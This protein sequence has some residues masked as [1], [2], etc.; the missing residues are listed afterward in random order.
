MPENLSPSPVVNTEAIFWTSSW[1]FHR[2]QNIIPLLQA[3]AKGG[4]H[5][6]RRPESQRWYLKARWQLFLLSEHT[7]GWAALPRQQYPCKPKHAG[8]E[9]WPQDS[10][11]AC[12]SR[13]TPSEQVSKAVPVQLQPF[14]RGFLLVGEPLHTHIWQPD[15][16]KP[17]GKMHWHSMWNPLGAGTFLHVCPW[18][19]RYTMELLQKA[20][21][22]PSFHKCPRWTI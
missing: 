15:C 8:E 2:N 22:L 1:P 18:Q 9:G 17:F 6:I 11:C 14:A 12:M 4:K 3:M 5:S 21:S 10:V 19:P 20:T 16:L 7:A 13:Q